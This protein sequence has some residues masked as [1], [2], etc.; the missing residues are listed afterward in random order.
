MDTK[1]W[2]RKYLAKQKRKGLMLFVGLAEVLLGILVLPNT[3]GDVFFMVGALLM[4]GSG[5]YLL[6][7]VFN[8]GSATKN[9]MSMMEREGRLQNVLSDFR[10]AM[11]CMG[12][13]LRLG[14]QWIYGKGSGIPYEYGNIIRVYQYVHK[15]NFAEDSRQ[16]H[17]TL[18]TG[19]TATLCD[20][21]VGGAQEQELNRALNI[22]LHY[23]PNIQI[24]YK[25]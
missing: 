19:G 25:K 1:E 18:K 5:C 22:M 9:W 11:D 12:G 24:G 10:D 7:N 4:L 20:L 6:Y 13:E 8:G 14:Q 17:A 3:D 15:T 23:N 16:L 2:M 21:P